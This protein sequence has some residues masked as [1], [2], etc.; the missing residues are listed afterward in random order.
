LV[1]GRPAVGRRLTA[2]ATGVCHRRNK[3]AWLH[4]KAVRCHRAGCGYCAINAPSQ[5]AMAHTL[6]AIAFRLVPH[7]D[8]GANPLAPS[9]RHQKWGMA[10]TSPAPNHQNCR[11]S[12]RNHP[13]RAMVPFEWGA[14]W[15]VSTPRFQFGKVIGVRQRRW[16]ERQ[17][18]P[19]RQVFRI[20]VERDAIMNALLTR[21][22]LSKQTS[23]REPI[24]RALS[25][26]VM[27]WAGAVNASQEVK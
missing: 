22:H 18:V 13:S 14:P 19:L 25:S 24:E 17:K 7:P 5:K 21:G 3:T 4:G 15:V 26:V 10:Q 12:Y 16:R 2:T 27:Q 20:E 23:H 11:Y 8:D 9:V 1:T 6:C